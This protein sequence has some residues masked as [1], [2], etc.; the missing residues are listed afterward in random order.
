MFWYL[1]VFYDFW[2]CVLNDIVI[3]VFLYESWYV[4]GVFD[5]C[6]IVVDGEVKNDVGGYGCIFCSEIGWLIFGF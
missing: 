1:I 2:F 3:F 4:V 6:V 5:K